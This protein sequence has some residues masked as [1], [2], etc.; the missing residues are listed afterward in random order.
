[1][2]HFKSRTG[3]LQIHLPTFKVYLPTFSKGDKIR[4]VNLPTLQIG[5]V[6]F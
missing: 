5:V 6:T 1:M 3:E 2:L 4:Q